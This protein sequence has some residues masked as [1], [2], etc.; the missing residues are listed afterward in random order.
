M[1]GG[2]HLARLKVARRCSADMNISLREQHAVS[3]V[4]EMSGGHGCDIYIEVTR[5]PRAMRQ[6]LDMICKHGRFMEVIVSREL[7]I[8]A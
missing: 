1:S 5:A 2:V 3:M 8:T 4:K 6:G 7:V